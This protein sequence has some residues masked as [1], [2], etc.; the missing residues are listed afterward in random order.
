VPTGS[1]VSLPDIDWEKSRQTL[2]LVLD[3]ECRYCTASAPFYQQIVRESANNHRVQL[4]AAFPQ[5][6]SKG[7]QYLNDLNVP[8]TEVRQ[9]SLN[10]LGVKGTPTL[11]L[12]NSKAE[13][14]RSWPGKLSSEEE[15]EVLLKIGS[16][17]AS[18]VLKPARETSLGV[19]FQARP[20][21]LIIKLRRL[22]TVGSHE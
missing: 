7:K 13:V 11:I 18:S 4:I 16:L 1:K 20:R 9:S 15:K 8:I 3:T 22:S 19:L 21:S 10:A 14:L 6:I 17:N 12:I 2:L 5:E